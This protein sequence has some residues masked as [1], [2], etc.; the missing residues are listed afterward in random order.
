MISRAGTTY[1][2]TPALLHFTARL[3]HHPKSPTLVFIASSPSPPIV[4]YNNTAARADLNWYAPIFRSLGVNTTDINDIQLDDGGAGFVGWGD[5]MQIVGPLGNPSESYA[6][7]DKSMNPEG[8]DAGNFWADDSMTPVDVVFDEGDGIA[9][10]NPN[11]FAYNIVGAGE[12]S[13]N[14]VVFGANADLNWSGNPFPMT[15]GINS[16]Q[17]DDDGAGFVGWGDTLQIVGPLGNPSESYAYW[18]KSMNPEGEDAGNFWADDSMTPVDV[19][20]APGAG[21][22]IDNPNGFTY[23]I[24]I[25]CK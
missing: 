8:E 12:V 4:G 9:I 1:P 14:Q 6:Y 15:I 23:N 3:L 21:F 18:D 11:G 7:W 17:L 20:I 5:T 13:T 10:D 25:N 16:I 19:T 24:I 2:H 22:A